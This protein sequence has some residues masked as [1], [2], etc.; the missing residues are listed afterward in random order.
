MNLLTHLPHFYLLLRFLLPSFFLLFC[1][2][3]FCYS[4]NLEWTLAAF[5]NNFKTMHCLLREFPFTFLLP[6]LRQVFPQSQRDN[7]SLVRSRKINVS[8]KYEAA[9][10]YQSAR[11]NEKQAN[12]DTCILLLLLLLLPRLSIW[13]KDSNRTQC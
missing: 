9:L 10:S 12:T 6:S 13:K 7:I 8:H 11:G 4:M 2:F 1:V 5:P 3:C